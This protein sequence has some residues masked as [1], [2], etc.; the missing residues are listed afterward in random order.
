MFAFFNSLLQEKEKYT[1]KDIRATSAF[2]Q[3]TLTLPPF[4]MGYWLPLNHGSLHLSV[5]LKTK[6]YSQLINAMI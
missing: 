3:V 2:C 1:Y 6:H 4:N 5:I